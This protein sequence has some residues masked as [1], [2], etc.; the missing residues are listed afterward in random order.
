MQRG[1]RQPVR[2]TTATTPRPPPT[3]RSEPMARIA[4][5][6]DVDTLRGTRE[7]VP[8]AGQALLQ[9]VGA[10]ATFLFSLGPDHTGRAILRVFRPGFLS[11]VART[12]VVEHYGVRTLL[13]GT[14]AA[15]PRHRPARGRAR[16]A[17]C[18]T[19]ASRS[20]CIAGTTCAGRTTCSQRDAAWT[21][22]QMTRAVERH[23]Q[24]FGSAA[25]PAWRRRLAVQRG[26]RAGR[27]DARHHAGVGHPRRGGRSCRSPTTA[28]VIGPPQFP[29]TLPTLDELIGIDGVDARE[30]RTATCWA[31]RP[32]PTATRST[33]C[34]PS[35]RA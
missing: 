12:S 10:G 15:G 3:W 5:K 8:R 14:P 20:A 7:G 24:I 13:Y 28:R 18:A 27:D 29:T 19:P 4:L 26:G 35:S 34:T 1:A 32:A 31:S 23:T 6:I 33:R 9:R 21:L 25:A 17:R 11:K 22:R 16:C 30:R 2:R